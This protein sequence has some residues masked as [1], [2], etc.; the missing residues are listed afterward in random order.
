VSYAAPPKVP[1]WVGTL[2]LGAFVA[3]IVWALV[4]G[5]PRYSCATL[6]W[7]TGTRTRYRLMAGCFV[8]I[9]GR[10]MPQRNWR[11]PR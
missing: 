7:E 6:E 1:A 4:D 5:L 11:A 8:D 2:A 3:L 10:W 9:D